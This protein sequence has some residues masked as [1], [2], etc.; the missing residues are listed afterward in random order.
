MF[1]AIISSKLFA[2]PVL[3]SYLKMSYMMIRCHIVQS[4]Q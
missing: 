4:L 1:R 2:A 3:L